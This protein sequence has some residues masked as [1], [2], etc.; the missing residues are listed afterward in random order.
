MPVVAD[1][2]LEEQEPPYVMVPASVDEKVLIWRGIRS[3][4]C[5]WMD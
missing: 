3:W 1:V 4:G 5:Y 2:V